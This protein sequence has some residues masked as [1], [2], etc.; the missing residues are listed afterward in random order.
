MQEDWEVVICHIPIV[1]NL[2]DDCLTHVAVRFT[3]GCR[4]LE[5]PPLNAV[6]MLQRDLKGLCRPIDFV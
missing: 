4:M 5:V 3:Y 1:Q 2:V 6:S